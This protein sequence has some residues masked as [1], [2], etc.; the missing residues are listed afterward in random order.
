MRVSK[1]TASGLRDARS[2]PL[3]RRQRTACSIRGAAWRST[4]QNASSQTQ[5]LGRRWN[6]YDVPGPLVRTR[7]F[8]LRDNPAG[9]A[10]RAGEPTSAQKELAVD[11]AELEALLEP[12]PRRVLQTPPPVPA[13]KVDGCPRT[14]LRASR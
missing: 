1:G 13:K 9:L 8:S 4:S 12:I 10:I 3:G 5:F 11:A 2:D 14:I 6:G 7:Y